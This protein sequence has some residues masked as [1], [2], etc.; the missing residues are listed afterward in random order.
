MTPNTAVMNAA[1]RKRRRT[2][3]R[4]LEALVTASISMRAFGILEQ[5]W[6]VNMCKIARQYD[7][8]MTHSTIPV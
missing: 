3:T 1:I 6:F 7:G 2:I 5:N 8:K 4:D